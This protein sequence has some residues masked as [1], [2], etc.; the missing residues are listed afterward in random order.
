M[1]QN[2]LDVVDVRIDRSRNDLIARSIVY[3]FTNVLDGRGISSDEGY[4]N[5]DTS[6][7]HFFLE[8]GQG[9]LVEVF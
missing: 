7:R 1:S 8:T 3:E 6:R 2:V 4:T 5:R 9:G